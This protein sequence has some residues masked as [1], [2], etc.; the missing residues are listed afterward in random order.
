V[1]ISNKYTCNIFRCFFFR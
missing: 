1:I